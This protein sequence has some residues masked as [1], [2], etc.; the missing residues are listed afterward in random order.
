M[1]WCLLRE[2]EIM[3]TQIATFL[4]LLSLSSQTITFD[5]LLVY[6]GEWQGILT[7][8][9]YGDDQTLVDLPVR[10]VATQKKDRLNFEYYYNE[11]DGR[12]EKRTGSF[13]V[14][15]GKIYYNGKWD[16]SKSEIEDLQNWSLELV[17]EGKDNN[18]PA[19]FKK[20]VEVSPT[21]IEVTK[22]VKYEGESDYFMRNKHVFIK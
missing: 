18:K 3:K 17:S 4:L 6:E 5:H 12:T 7:Y 1:I 19:S 15:K 9:N 22:W 10:M 13:K 16:V 8:L 14:S 2:K 21:Y 11:G 20:T